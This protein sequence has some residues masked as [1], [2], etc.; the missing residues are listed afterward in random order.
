MNPNEKHED[1]LADRGEERLRALGTR[2]PRCSVLGCE[3]D[4]PFAL[5]GAEP[6]ILCREHLADSQGRSWTEQHH[7]PGQH[8][9]PST[10]PAPANDHGALSEYQALWPRETLRN[11]DGSPLLR[12]AAAIRGW[13]DVLWVII[14]RTVG[15]IPAALESLNQLLC[16]RLGDRWWEGLGWQP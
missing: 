14:H 6:N 9:D 8:N 16:D 12:A 11:P 4:D 1:R 10:L 15:W 3:E 2:H 13:L 7:V 5:T